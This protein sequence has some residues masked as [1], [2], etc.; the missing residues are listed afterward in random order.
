MRNGS[1]SQLKTKEEDIELRIVN[2]QYFVSVTLS[3]HI[4]PKGFSVRYQYFS[5]LDINNGIKL[6]EKLKTRVLMQ[7]GDMIWIFRPAERR[8]RCLTF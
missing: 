8:F 6:N 3:Y 2:E 1:F 5:V 4:Y 7:V